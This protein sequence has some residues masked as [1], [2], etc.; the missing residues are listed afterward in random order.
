[1]ELE[2][3]VGGHSDDDT[4]DISYRDV[5]AEIIEQLKNDRDLIAEIEVSKDIGGQPVAPEV[6]AA[7]FVMAKLREHKPDISDKDIRRFLSHIFDPVFAVYNEDLPESEQ[8]NS[9]IS[10]ILRRA[11]NQVASWTG[12]S[13]KR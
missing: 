9:K 11:I 13:P 4:E 5:Q 1:M 10:D 6:F 2:D 8:K 12:L 7:T 3:H